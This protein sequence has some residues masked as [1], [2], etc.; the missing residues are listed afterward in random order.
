MYSKN[1]SVTHMPALQEDAGR[2]GPED[3]S[4]DQLLGALKLNLT[5]PQCSIPHD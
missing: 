2:A 4:M 5:Q 3:E 1:L